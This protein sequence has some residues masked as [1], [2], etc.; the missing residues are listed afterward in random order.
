MA[1]LTHQKSFMCDMQPLTKKKKKEGRE[2]KE[3]RG[4]GRKTVQLEEWNVFSNKY[5]TLPSYRTATLLWY[6]GFDIC[7]YHDII[8]VNK[9]RYMQ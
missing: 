2:C 4:R 5:S 7:M 8:K 6:N 3:E 1:L 9:G